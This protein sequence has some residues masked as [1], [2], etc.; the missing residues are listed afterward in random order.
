MDGSVQHE[1][2]VGERS[3]ER[4]GEVDALNL[5][6]RACS[7]WRDPASDN[8]GRRRTDNPKPRPNFAKHQLASPSITAP[9]ASKVQRGEESPQPFDRQQHQIVNGEAGQ[10]FQRAAP[11]LKWRVKSVCQAATASALAFDPSRKLIDVGFSRAP[12]SALQGV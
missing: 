6:A 4:G 5:A 12:S 11:N 3:A 2:R 7:S 1:Q 9:T 8:R 10:H